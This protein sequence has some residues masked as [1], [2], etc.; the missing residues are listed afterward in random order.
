M[1]RL[2]VRTKL[3]GS[4]LVFCVGIGLGTYAYVTNQVSRQAEA[5]A[6]QRAR[7]QINLLEEVRQYYT[8]HVVQPALQHKVEATYDAGRKP[9]TIPLPA[10]LIHDLSERV[11]KQD[12]TL[13]RLFSRYPFPHRAAQAQALDDFEEEALETLTASPK[14]DVWRRTR[15]RD[16]DVVRLA[17][18]DVMHS[19]SCVQC[20]NSHP[21]SPRKDWRLGD[22][23]GVLEVIVPI[24]QELA[25]AHAGARNMSLAIFGGLLLLTLLTAFILR[26]FIFT[27]LQS[28]ER[29]ARG[30]ASGDMQQV[31]DY[32]SGDEIGQLAE[33]FRQT[34]GYLG[35]VAGAADALARGDLSVRLQPRSERDTVSHSVNRC[36]D[37]LNGL[38]A[39]ANLLLEA[40]VAGRLSTRAD[41]SRHQ[42][43]FRKIV[44]GVNDTLDA[45]V[46]PVRESASVLARVANG[47][48]TARV[49]GDYRGDHA[50]I[51]D[52]INAMAADLAGSMTGIAEHAQTLASSAEELS[53]VSVQMSAG[54]EETSAQAVAAS[55]AGEQVSRNGQTVAAAVEEMGA[56]I[57]EIAR[58]AQEAARMAATAVTVAQ[59]TNDTITRLGESSEQIGKVIKVI[60]AV[61]EQTNLLALNAT[62]EAARAGEAGKGFAVVANEVKELA[63]ETARATEDISPR[64]E[65][66][67]KNTQGAVEAISQVCGL[68]GQISDFQ[69][70]IASAVEEQTATT[71][72]IARNVAESARGSSEI[73]HGIATMA[74]AAQGT[75]EGTGQVQGAAAALA[76]LAA[77]LQQRVDRFRC[78]AGAGAPPPAAPEQAA[79]PPPLAPSRR[80][81]AARRSGNGKR[82][83]GSTAGRT[84]D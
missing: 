62:I 25:A 19:P 53:A 6:V 11:S 34:L 4:I 41:A 46:E 83:N 10:T 51:K 47:D 45:V 72:E 3:L 81:R 36:V 56:S 52:S 66:I 32:R 1:N 24:D 49:R 12:G 60:T 33:S 84:H 65:A 29:A 39:D 78:E 5:A 30:L 63:K 71:N 15:Y 74:E 27:P 48:L 58:S 77:E 80:E 75:A 23:R 18:A 79:P 31:V 20:H 13:I 64:I 73:A 76:E 68:I 28:M 61:A 16:R 43:D 7:Q 9:G 55:S 26:R 82:L 54:A 14:Q 2:G 42:G 35:G 8:S 17:A 69:N 59:S 38:I 57:R 70:T 44:Q 37:T 50:A 21:Q 67:Q 40:A 22:V